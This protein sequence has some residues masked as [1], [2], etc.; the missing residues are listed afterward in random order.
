MN[1]VIK[2]TD[3]PD[4]RKGQY[5]SQVGN[6]KAYVSFAKA[7]R[8]ATRKEAEANLCPENETI[9]HVSAGG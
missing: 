4:G 7:R 3:E 1:Y 5:V 8:F 6:P 2:R 9:I